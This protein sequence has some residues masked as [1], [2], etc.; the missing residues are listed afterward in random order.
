M[1]RTELRRKTPMKRTGWQRTP[2]AW[3]AALNTRKPLAKVSA[4]R[5][6]VNRAQKPGLDE[7]RE[8]FPDCQIVTCRNSATQIHEITNGPSRI[9]GRGERAAILHVCHWCNQDLCDKGRYPLAVQLA[10]K[11]LSDERGFNLSRV[12]EVLDLGPLAVEFWEVEAIAAGLRKLLQPEWA[13]GE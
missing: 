3:V 11:L 9:R 13:K 8:K 1:R 5:R 4:K 7:Y 6:K 2:R 10:H 12:L